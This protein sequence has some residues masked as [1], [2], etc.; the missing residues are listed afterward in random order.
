MG[1]GDWG[2][3]TGDWGQEEKRK[4]FYHGVIQKKREKGKGKKVRFKSLNFFLFYLFI[5]LL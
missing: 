3:G 1:T 4:N 5:F 2:L